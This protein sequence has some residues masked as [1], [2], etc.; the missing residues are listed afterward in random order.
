MT[1]FR[2]KLL[3]M[4]TLMVCMAT[5]VV[6]PHMMRGDDPGGNPALEW[7]PTNTVGVEARKTTCVVSVSCI[8]K[9]MCINYDGIATLPTASI[10]YKSLE[11]YVDH[12]FGN[13]QSDVLATEKCFLTSTL[14]TSV[15]LYNKQS[16]QGNAIGSFDV[17]AKNTCVLP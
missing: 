13:C 6:S 4:L 14:C 1:K 10:P 11:A 9:D 2:P 3:A 16:C 15:F 17:Y 8:Q 12:P 5:S 7:S